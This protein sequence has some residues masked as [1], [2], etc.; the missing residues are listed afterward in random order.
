V[1]QG[2]ARRR[3]SASEIRERARETIEL[4]RS[5]TRVLME[6]GLIPAAPGDLPPGQ[7]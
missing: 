6:K 4:A 3:L 7:I 5:K 2:L 1:E